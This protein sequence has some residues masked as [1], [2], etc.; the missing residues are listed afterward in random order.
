M[1]DPAIAS[2]LR[3]WNL[4][5]DGVEIATPSA[6]LLPVRRDGAPAMLKV[7]SAASDEA[8]AAEA[9]RHFTGHNVVAVLEEDDG[10]MLLERAVPGT[11]L[12][13]WVAAGRDD[14]AT[15]IIA[16]L[17]ESLD[18]DEAP[19]G[20]PT[21]EEWGEAFRRQRARGG[22]PVLPPAMLDRAEALWRDL[23]ASQDRRCLLHGDLH[24]D[25]VL[26][27]GDR[28]LVVDPKGV[29]GEPA[30]EVVTALGNP[31][32]LWPLAADA[33]RMARRVAIFSERLGLDR[34]RVAAWTFAHRVLSACWTIEDGNPDLDATRSLAVA[35]TAASLL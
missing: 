14:E 10:A 6:R 16:G 25:N 27:D 24:H 28:W 12:T 4:V 29:V 33:A 35:E 20:W 5:P 11:P 22:H 21:L 3:R 30:F 9:L 2:R 1:P 15:A 17:A 34:E 18:R 7:M 31:V 19:P 26:R 8:H 13:E 23:C 32:R